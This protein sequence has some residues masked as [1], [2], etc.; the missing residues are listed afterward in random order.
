VAAKVD[1]DFQYSH[2]VKFVTIDGSATLLSVAQST[3]PRATVG[4]D[5]RHLVESAKRKAA[6][7]APHQPDIV[8]QTGK[9]MWSLCRVTTMDEFKRLWGMIRGRRCTTPHGT[10]LPQTLI[11]HLAKHVV[12]LIPSRVLAIQKDGTV[13]PSALTSTGFHQASTQPAESLNATF[14]R[15]RR[16]FGESA[17]SA[18]LTCAACDLFL[19][20]FE[21]ELDLSLGG[22]GTHSVQPDARSAVGRDGSVDFKMLIESSRCDA[23]VDNVGL[24]STAPFSR[25]NRKSK[26]SILPKDSLGIEALMSAATAPDSVTALFSPILSKEVLLFF[27]SMTIF[28]N[29]SSSTHLIFWQCLFTS[30]VSASQY[31]QLGSKA[32]GRGWCE[33]KATNATHMSLNAQR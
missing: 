14:S 10:Q 23:S 9:D 25:T 32:T 28:L 18:L 13:P 3:F 27:K 26:A 1:P 7:L 12:D 5:A 17:E 21:R 33:A 8:S 19:T 24:A 11:S 20:S 29:I 16:N 4:L 6:E 30:F 22:R 2:A 31:I 15:F